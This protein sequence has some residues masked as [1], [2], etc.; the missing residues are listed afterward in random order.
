MEKREADVATAGASVVFYERWRETQDGELL[1]KIYDYNR[2]DCISTQLLRDWLIRD[3][4]PESLP[5][6]TLGEVSDAGPLAN[7][8]AEDEEMAALRERLLPVRDR[9]GE[10]NAD[11]DRKSTRLNYSH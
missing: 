1:D 6:P 3:V 10:D 9:L 4:R 8:E 5:W 11:L 2:T 7:V